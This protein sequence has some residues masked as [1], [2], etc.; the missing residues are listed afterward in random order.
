LQKRS[1]AQSEKTAFRSPHDPNFRECD[2]PVLTPLILDQDYFTEEN[3]SWLRR[4]WPQATKLQKPND[5]ARPGLELQAM[6]TVEFDPSTVSKRVKTDLRRN[7]QLLDD[8]EKKQVQQIYEAALRSVLARR[9]LHVLFTALMKIAGMTQG[10][11]AEIAL[12][13]NN[14]ATAI[15]NRDRQASLGIAYAKWMYSNAPCMRDPR[16]PATAD[17]QQDSAHCSANG[18]K[19]EISKGLFVD[20]KWTWPGVEEGC[21]CSSRAILP[22]LEE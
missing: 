7:V 12:S 13:L 16:H 14:K 19:Y 20:G 10:R 4:L 22:G 8:L 9:D 6:P 18:K 5:H 11:A 21:K 2:F 17:V 1:F 15:I 3:M